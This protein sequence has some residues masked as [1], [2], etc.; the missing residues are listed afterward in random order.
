M[1]TL[2]AS[3]IT[4]SSALLY[5][6]VNPNNELTTNVFWANTNLSVSGTYYNVGT[7]IVPAGS[8]PVTVSNLVTGLLPGEPYTYFVAATNGA[9]SNTGTPANFT[10]KVNLGGTTLNADHNLAFT[11]TSAPG[12]S[13][14]SLMVYGTTNLNP[15]LWQNLGAA[16][17]TATPGIYTFT[18]TQTTNRPQQFY[19]VGP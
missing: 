6:A 1:T 16:Q 13:P 4:A 10:T 11:F 2:A 12:A 3:N 15:A 9:G 19:K 7:V 5:A 17:E 14:G 18:D 8:S